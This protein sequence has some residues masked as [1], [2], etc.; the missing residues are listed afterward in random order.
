[1]LM[2]FGD[3]R[4]SRRDV[5]QFDRKSDKRMP[6]THKVIRN[7]PA[8]RLYL[9]GE[10]IDLSSISPERVAQL[11]D[12]RY[13]VPLPTRYYCQY[14]SG[15]V[16]KNAL[17]GRPT[18]L[19]TTLATVFIEPVGPPSYDSF[20]GVI[21]IVGSG[22]HTP[23]GIRG[24]SYYSDHGTENEGAF[25]FD[26]GKTFYEITGYRFTLE[27]KVE[28]YLRLLSMRHDRV[29]RKRMGLTN[30]ESVDVYDEGKQ[31]AKER[32][33]RGKPSFGSG[34]E[35]YK[36]PDDGILVRPIAEY[37]V[38]L[39]FAGE[40]RKYVSEVAA[41]LKGGGHPCILRRL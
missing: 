29:R 34:N 41:R 23:D 9:A 31:A 40:D 24:Y 20:G 22:Y 33:S 18:N 35:T 4:L 11:V 3:G 14:A 28:V 6:P 10:E 8:D 7:L 5:L 36:K 37:D 32:E 2:K 1:M 16:L 38:A 19:S 17:E 27:N 39:S 13:V 30:G 12:Q 25:T 15:S 21:G 26:E